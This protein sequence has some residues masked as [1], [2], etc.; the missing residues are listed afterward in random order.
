[1]SD[2]LHTMTAEELRAYGDARAA[3]ARREAL[4]EA[5]ELCD[6]L[7]DRRLA[8]DIRALAQQAEPPKEG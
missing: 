6:L 7:D 3:E 4:E 8:A 2:V 5:A 1:M